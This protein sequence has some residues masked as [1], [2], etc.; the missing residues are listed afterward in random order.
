M[1]II[2]SILI[3]A[4]LF[5]CNN[6]GDGGYV[7]LDT[8]RHFSIFYFPQDTLKKDRRF[9]HLQKIRADSVA[10]TDNNGKKVSGTSVEKITYVF[11]F[12]DTARDDITRK[13]QLDSSGNTYL[14][15]YFIIIPKENIDYIDDKDIGPFIFGKD[16]VSA[17]K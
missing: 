16:S 14:K 9:L 10:I 17:G 11:Y 1:K 3:S 5:S 7:K 15:Q 6:S 2:Y 8:S 4:I 13:I 12:I